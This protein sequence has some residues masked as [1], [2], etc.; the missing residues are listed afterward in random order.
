M[1]GART[2]DGRPGTAGAAFT[3][4]VLETFRL[5]GQLLA[6]SDRLSGKASLSTA[7]WQVL[8]AV[9]EQPLPVA[10]IARTLGLTRQS[11]QRTVDLLAEAGLVE[12]HDN[13]HHQRAKLIGLTSDGR[14][15]LSIVNRAHSNWSQ[16]MASGIRMR[17][18]NSAASTLERLRQKIERD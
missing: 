16:Q 4:L 7:R 10:W 12:F 5:N 11:V 15:S 14:S 8:D 3:R 2:R 13:P 6:A 9:A 18:M 17:D 1:S